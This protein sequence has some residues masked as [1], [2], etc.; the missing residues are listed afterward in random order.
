MKV[1]AWPLTEHRIVEKNVDG[2]DIKVFADRP[3]SL[4]DLLEKSVLQFPDKDALIYQDKRLSYR[5]FKEKVDMVSVSLQQECRVGKGDRVAVLF[6]NTLEFCV[7]YF[8]IVQIGAVCQPVNYRLTADEMQYQLK[9]TAAKVIILEE[10]YVDLIKEIISDLPEMKMVFVSDSSYSG[11]FKNFEELEKKT[12]QSLIETVIDEEDLASIVYTS[13]TTGRPKGT[14]ISHRNLICNAISF[15]SISKM[16]STTKQIIL[17]PL[18]HASALHSQL[19]TGILKGATSVIMKEFKTKDSMALM[20]AEKVNLVVAVPTMYWF[21]VNDPD[22]E[23]YDLTSIRCT[24]SGAA[25]AA[26]ELIKIL[27]Q[28][29]PRSRFINAGGQT[30]STSCTFA[31]PPEDALRKAGSIGWAT[32][33]NEIKVMDIKE[34]ECDFNETGELWFKGPAIAKGYWNNPKGT[35][36]TFIDGWVK[37]GDIGKVDEEGYLYL[38]DRKKDMIIRGGE[39]IYCVEVENALYSHPKVL[40]AAVVGVPDKIFGEQVKAVVVMKPGKEAT[41]EE[42][43]E[44]C[45][46]K[47]ADY[48]VPKYVEFRTELPRNPGGK[49][50]KSLL[51]AQ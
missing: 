20:S 28:K 14:M 4:K 41:E 31:L 47:L 30:E 43:R 10:K 16:D 5:D 13:G 26:P 22:F 48:K 37:T 17:T 7:C 42:I 35:K 8:A 18:F 51:K 6:T 23:N 33:P 27:A 39:N 45:G 11:E 50:V 24:L 32:P 29:F 44:F 21:W 46:S 40:E 15:S 3:L 19:I 34:E 38:L 2:V 12:S 9:D 25:P 49:V 1:K 36:E